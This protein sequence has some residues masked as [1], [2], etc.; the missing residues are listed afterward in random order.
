M[1]NIESAKKFYP[2]WTIR[3][4]HDDS[5]DHSIICDLEC[6]KDEK[7]DY[8]NNI[9]FCDVKKIPKTLDTSVDYSYMLRMVWRWL[10]I[11]D[12]FVDVFISRDT[13]SCIFEREVSAVN[14]WLSSETLF[15][16]MRDSP[17]HGAVGYEMAGGLWG[18]KTKIDRNLAKYQYSKIT[19]AFLSRWYTL[20]SIEKGRD[21]YLLNWYFWPYAKLNSTVHDS[22][23]CLEFGGGKPF[24]SQRPLYENCFVGAPGCCQDSNR[25][26]RIECPEACRFDKKWKF[27]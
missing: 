10:P 9:D 4:Y 2:D 14:D 23:T 24:P 26:Y 27:C 5:I 6:I 3:I 22:Y 17:A 25:L 12:Q 19:S 20:Y 13:D 21:Q 15:H 18:L 7:E 1:S 16:V 8:L 11:G